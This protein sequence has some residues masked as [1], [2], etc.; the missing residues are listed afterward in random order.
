MFWC[1]IFMRFWFD[2]QQMLGNSRRKLCQQ[3]SPLSRR[4]NFFDSLSSRRLRLIKYLTAIAEEEVKCNMNNIKHVFPSAVW[5]KEEKRR[6]KSWESEK[7]RK[8]HSKVCYDFFLCSTLP[9]NAKSFFLSKAINLLLLLFRGR[10]CKAKIIWY[11]FAL[12][13]VRTGILIA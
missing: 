7:K 6:K 2:R 11:F 1:E 3:T 5:G 13:R 8:T 9:K 12:R 4:R 10:E